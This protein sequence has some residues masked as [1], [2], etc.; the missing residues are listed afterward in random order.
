MRGGL[1]RINTSKRASI[2]DFVSSLAD[3]PVL[4]SRWWEQ[5]TSE[6]FHFNFSDSFEKWRHKPSS[7]PLRTGCRYCLAL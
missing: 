7:C 6:Y 2:Q 3:F 1:V 4:T 5:T